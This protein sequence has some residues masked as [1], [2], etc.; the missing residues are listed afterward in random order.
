MHSLSA[1]LAVISAKR[2]SLDEPSLGYRSS[3]RIAA[4]SNLGDRASA[5]RWQAGARPRAAGLRELATGL[6]QP[7]RPALERPPKRGRA[8]AAGRSR[9]YVL[10][11][12]RSVDSRSGRRLASLRRTNARYRGG[13]MRL[14]I[15]I[16]SVVGAAL[17]VAASAGAAPPD[18]FTDS[19]SYTGSESGAYELWSGSF[20]VDGKD[21]VRQE[22]K[23]RLTSSTGSG[24][25]LN[26]RPET[27]TA[28]P[29]LRLQHRL[30][31]RDGHD[32]DRQGHQGDVS[33]PRPLVPRCGENCLWPWRRR[34]S[35]PRPHDT[36]QGQDATATRSSR[37]RAERSRRG[38]PAGGSP[39]HGDPPAR[40]SARRL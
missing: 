27:V 40:E 34:G 19:D 29:S 33:R 23:P 38:D 16:A 8:R 5:W 17:L 36:E 12:A 10:M 4:H 32:V 21:D 25:E 15:G 9:T 2:S 3:Q 30:H 31:L 20:T 7:K 11:T 24:S 18:H 13:N 6:S 35:S 28:T 1:R 22:R 14:W 26:W 39:D 37:S